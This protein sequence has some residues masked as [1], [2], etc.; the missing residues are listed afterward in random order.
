MN[1]IDQV[2]M[3]VIEEFL[4]SL[5]EKAFH[6]GL[7]VVLAALALLMGV[8]LIKLIRSILRKALQRSRVDESAVKFLDSFAKYGLCFLLIIMIASWMGVDAASILALLGS[9]SVAIGLALQGSISNMAGGVLLLILK[10]FSLGDY[11]RDEKG[12]EGTVSAIDVFYT[13][14]LTFDNKVVVIPNGTLV[15]GC[16]TNYTRCDKR[17]LDISVGIAYEEDIR[18]AKKVLEEVLSKE[19]CVLPE[20]DKRVFVDALGDS[21]VVMNVRCWVKTENYWEVKWRMTEEIKYAL[22]EAGIRIPFPQMDVHVDSGV[23]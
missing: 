8:Q 11:I 13:Q 21:A 19:K 14:I 1:Q 16:I 9:A 2:E 15:N 18:S 17:R 5:P 10:P 22:D 20:E 12:N 7:R 4:Q 23:K 6:L 3:G